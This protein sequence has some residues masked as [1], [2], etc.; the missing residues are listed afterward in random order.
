MKKRVIAALLT[1]VMLLGMLPMSVFASD[2]EGIDIHAGTVATVTLGRTSIG[3]GTAKK[4]LEKDRSDFSYKNSSYTTGAS[5]TEMQVGDTKTYSRLLREQWAGYYYT[6]MNW[7]VRTEEC[8]TVSDPE[9]VG[10]FQY[11]LGYYNDTNYPCL[12]FSYTAKKTGTATINLVYYYNYG[13]VA[14]GSG[15]PIIDGTT[16]WKMT[17]TIKVTVTDADVK[18]EKPTKEDIE[19]FQ[20]ELSGWENEEHDKWAVACLCTENNDHAIAWT[21]LTGGITITGYSLGEV[22]ANDGSYKTTNGYPVTKSDY[23]W[24]CTMTVNT[25]D[26]VDEYNTNKDK[27]CDE[28]T[29]ATYGKHKLADGEPATK[30]VHWFYSAEKKEWDWLEDAPLVI[31]VVCAPEADK[32]KL[33]YDGN[34]PEG[35]TLKSVP[36]AEEKELL[37]NGTNFTITSEEPKLEDSKYVF[38]GW[39]DTVDATVANANYA[40]GTEITLTADKTLYAVWMYCYELIQNFNYPNVP[41]SG[42]WTSAAYTKAESYKLPIVT[43]KDGNP[44][45]EGYEFVGWAD[46]ADATEPK[47]E[48]VTG[49]EFTLTV[50]KPTKTIYAV[51][52]AIQPTGDDIENALKDATDKVTV[53]CKTTELTCT[54]KEYS[55]SVGQPEKIELNQTTFNGNS[56]AYEIALDTNKFVTEYSKDTDA[57]H[58]AVAGTPSTLKWIIYWDKESNTWKA[59]LESAAQSKIGVEHVNIKLT[60]NANVPD[61]EAVSNMPDPDIKRIKM[62][63][64]VVRFDLSNKTPLR[65]GYTFRGWATDATAENPTFP[66]E[67]MRSDKWV[68]TT[69]NPNYVLYAIWQKDTETLTV[70]ITGSSI[71]SQKPYFL[72]DIFTVT[73]KANLGDA[74][75]TMDYT[76]SDGKRPF[77]LINT[78]QNTDGSYT[79]TYQIKQLTGNWYNVPFT[80]TAAKRT[81]TATDTESY[82]MNLR[83]RI[84]LTIKDSDDTEITDATVL[85]KNNYVADPDPTDRDAV[86]TYIPADKEYRCHD[87]AVSNDDS[88]TIIITLKDGRT[89]TLTTDKNGRDIR[90]MLKAG[91]EEIYCEYKFP[92]YTITGKLYLNGQEIYKPDGT[93]HYTKT[94]SGKFGTKIDYTP[95]KDWAKQLV[96][97]TLDKVNEP[98]DA[99]VTVYKD[100][101][102]YAPEEYF[103]DQRKLENYVFVDVTTYYGV[104]FNVDG[105]VSSK[106]TQKVVYNGQASAPQMADKTGYTFDGWYTS[107]DDDGSKYVFNTPVTK[108]LTLYAGYIANNYTVTF[109]PDGGEVD[110]TSKSVTYDST[111]GELP[112][113]IKAGYKFLGWYLG[114]SEITSTSTVTTAENHTLTAEWEKLEQPI[115]AYF[116]AVDTNGKT[117][118]LVKKENPEDADKTLDRLGLTYNSTGSWFTYGK[119][120][121]AG[122]TLEGVKAELSSIDPYSGNA[123]F[124][125]G[126][127]IVWTSLDLKPAGW[128]DVYNKENTNPAYHLDGELMFYSATFNNGLPEG[129]TETVG[130]MPTNYYGGIQD[131]Y[132]LDEGITLPEPTR[133]GYDFIG[134]KVETDAEDGGDISI[135]A[136][137]ETDG[138]ADDDAVILDAGKTYTF[139]SGNNVTFT[140]Q[141]KKHIYTVSV[142][143]WK[144]GKSL[145]FITNV[146]ITVG[147]NILD[148]IQAALNK[149]QT[150]RGETSTFFKV[151]EVK[152]ADQIADAIKGYHADIDRIYKNTDGHPE[153]TGND[154]IFTVDSPSGVH[155]NYLP[156]TYTVTFDANGGEGTM[157]SQTFTYD[158]AQALNENTFT[159]PGYTFVEWNTEADGSGTAYAD[160][161]EVSNLAT[162]GPVNLYAQW[163]ANP[164]LLI[165]HSNY[166]VEGMKEA[167]SESPQWKTDDYVILKNIGPT[168]F[169]KPGY[170]FAGWNTKA[171]GSGKLFTETGSAHKVQFTAADIDENDEAHLYA[172]WEANPFLLIYHSNYNVEGMKETTSQSPQWKTDDYVTLKHIESAGFAK[173]G[174][175]FAGWNTK[176]DGN[177]KLFTET[178]SAH[179]VQFTAADI[180]ENGE[181]HLYAQWTANTYTVEFDGNGAM[182][183]K[184]TDQIFTYDRAQDLTKNAFAKTGYTFAGWSTVKDGDVVYTDG[185]EVNNLSAVNGDVITLYAK[186]TANTYTVKFDGN[187]ATSGTMADQ[188]FTYD[189]A[190]KLTKNA[191]AKTGYTFAGWKDS[192]DNTYTDEQEVMNLIAIQGGVVTLTAQWTAD[193]IAVDLSQYVYKQYVQKYNRKD[194]TTFNFTAEVY[195][196]AMISSASS[197]VAVFANSLIDTVKGE[198]KIDSSKNGEVKQVTFEKTDKLS[199]GR[200]YVYITE[201]TEN[202]GTNSYITYDNSGYVLNVRVFDNGKTGLD[203]KLLGINKVGENGQMKTTDDT[204]VTFVNTYTRASRPST[205]S[206]SK[207]TLNTG[208]HYAYVMGYPDGTVRP[209]GSITRAEVSA[210][211]FRLLS[212]KTRDEYFTTESSFTDVKAG[213][214]YNNSIATLEKAGVIVDTAKG[215]AFRPNEAITRAELAAM[216]AQFSDAK[217]VKGVKFSDV[218]AE[219]WAYEAIAIAAK[220]GW[221]EGYPDGTFRPDATITRAEMMTLVNRALE[222]VPSDEDHLLSKRVMLTFPDCKSGD[223]FYIAVQEAT[224]SHTYERAATEK[225]GDEQWTALRA[226]RDWTL[227]EK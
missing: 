127:K 184:M 168:G 34:A 111:Y 118:I 6:P 83:N 174:Y 203:V 43:G 66:V 187:G 157:D 76:L 62:G 196:A 161:K 59:V 160:K 61:G 72:G 94:I 162:E 226:N 185:Q 110:P 11:S 31:N 225:N 177:G 195:P 194:T 182:S 193:P 69:G 181:A 88:G 90:K 171:D 139:E 129:S 22:V 99:V 10:D 44:T 214:W 3:T 132:L 146:D 97:E 219:H 170:T 104:T 42:S 220:M 95:L 192:R 128:H 186:W 68:S 120:M 178:G 119:L 150:F 37:Q 85:R 134:W 189:V 47:S 103:G 2:D 205:S 143:A 67:N 16:W 54:S 133:D 57:Q 78:T 15:R 144:N 32:V 136:N 75:V 40:A 107:V 51:W 116:K 211:L 123:G 4:I 207:P 70:D 140:A 48:Y 52:K 105:T 206:T 155:I 17:K 5:T 117:V 113:P 115:Y 175:T 131:Y 151:W 149:E 153:I 96:M 209:N 121:S 208:D 114:N 36:A 163:E 8:V 224:N 154:L 82:A 12:Q 77:E 217:P 93:S 142:G 30:T 152:N 212:D 222:R 215:G 25:Q 145:A 28:D 148:K 87:W 89:A 204:T 7:V 23:P 124:T 141:W 21:T 73:A 106:D 200:Y 91:T 130:N 60:Y 64:T 41:N 198:V 166:N 98:V 101:G 92:A 112:T 173:L 159:K 102:T 19:S 199:A 18:P 27:V 9:V 26:W 49:Y 179:K 20:D 55:P 158:A 108:S 84:H 172:Q 50:K 197:P 109:N 45:C 53:E 29:G 221:I 56:N 218:S 71:T 100:G 169:A 79:F 135:L 80:A 125:H 63:S 122:T 126:D 180:D 183:G 74:T 210:I 164:F 13:L 156:N 213:A 33:T 137:P 147:E 39:A 202:K 1:L 227:L 24:M 58:N 86:M 138:N 165:Y 14:D 35:E 223:W 38:V 46:T 188:D 81:Q 216:L 190:Q 201:N 167:T 176:V 65:T 191:F